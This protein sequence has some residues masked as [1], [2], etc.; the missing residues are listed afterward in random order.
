MRLWTSSAIKR[1]T[2]PFAVTALV[3]A[4]LIIFF[5]VTGVD[6]WLQDRI[7]NLTGRHWLLDGN[8][9]LLRLLFYDGI[10]L[11]FVAVVLLLLVLL[12]FFGNR[13]PV[14]RHRRGLLIVCLST[15]TVPLVV[16]LLKDHTNVPCPKDLARYGGEYPHVTLLY[17]Y[18]DTFRAEHQVRCY[19]AGHASGG[20]SLLSLAYLFR[21]RR[22][23]LLGLGTGL[24]LGWSTGLYKM[25]IGDHF[26]SHTVVTMVLAW[27]LISLIVRGVDRIAAAHRST[28]VMSLNELPVE[29]EA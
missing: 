6:L 28:S 10:K 9:P 20:F 27:L 22:K 25:L 21:G 11:V 24:V 26:L 12:L 18:P 8:Q 4:G 29:T 13:E 16:G 3:L 17:R 23:Q 1:L 15:I 2:S 19:P 14:R 5:E 7:Y